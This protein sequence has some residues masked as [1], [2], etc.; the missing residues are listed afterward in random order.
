MERSHNFN[1]E[2]RSQEVSPTLKFYKCNQSN[3]L[4][5]NCPSNESWPEKNE[6]KN[7]KE[8]ISKKAYIAWE[9][10]YFDINNK[11]IFVR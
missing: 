10:L 3:H 9:F 2:K 5:A 11:L 1:N 4:K 6:K 7:Y 8:R